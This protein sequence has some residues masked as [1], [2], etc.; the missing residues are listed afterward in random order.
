MTRVRRFSA[1]T[2]RSLH[3]RN[4]RLFFIGQLVSVTGTWMQQIAQDWLVLHLS[5]S[6]IAVGVTVGLQF[7]PMLLFGMTGGLIAD[8]FDKRK[9]LLY[10]QA[11]AGVLALIMGILV[12]TGAIQL[13]MVFIL[14]FLLGMV[15]AVDNPTRQS[16]VI[17]MVGPDEVTNAVGLNS[18][19]FN[20]ARVIGP[21]MAALIIEFVGLSPAFFVNS[22][23][24]GAAITAIWRMDVSLLQKTERGATRKGALKRGLQYVRE[25][26][27]LRSTIILVA[28]VATF[29]M[30]LGVVLPLLARFTFHGGAGTYGF[31]MAIMSLGA[32]GGALAAAARTEPNARLRVAMAGTFGAF[33]IL[34]AAAPN[35]ALAGVALIGAGAAGITFMA[36]SNSTLQLRS[37][38]HMRG[39]VM[40]LYAL[41]FLGS[42]P[43]G[44]PVVGWVSEQWSPRVALA[45]CGVVTV[46]GAATVGVRSL[47][48]M[49]VAIEPDVPATQAAA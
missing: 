41:V 4:Y 18:A 25:T 6:G 32:L 16:F 11:A 37:K 5:D 20:T 36:M 49:P 23:S 13:W 22:V 26:P 12:A 35:V 17:E 46:V 47:R 42:T 39:R 21:A 19:V 10:T 40:A 30:N 7:L 48:S 15:T 3:V 2:F 27:E 44:G 24:Y 33:E 8:R 34:T 31:L 43:I 28:V 9:V 14:A 45:L 38:P 1:V 29:G